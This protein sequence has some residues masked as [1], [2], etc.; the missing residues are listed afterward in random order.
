MALASLGLNYNERRKQMTTYII[1][2]KIIFEGEVEVKADDQTE[3]EQIAQGLGATIGEISDEG[4]SQ[5]I[6]WKIDNTPAE[7]ETPNM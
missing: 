7:I 6:D 3:A 1:P 5:I 2:V 4:C